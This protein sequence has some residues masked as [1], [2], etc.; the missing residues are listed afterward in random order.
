MELIDTHCHLTF[1]GL[2]EDVEGV[3]ERSRQAGVVQWITVGTD[4]EENLKVVELAGRFEG[5]YAAV[6]V[7]PHYASNVD[8]N[9]M[10]N[11]KDAANSEK[12]VAVGETGLDFHYN[13]SDKDSQKSVFQ[14]HLELAAETGLPVIV[15]C[16]DA[17]DDTMKLLEES[18]A[19][20]D[21][22][23]FHCFSGSAD[24]AGV[25]L[26]K[27]YYISF[28][29]VVTFKNAGHSREAAKAV[30]LN[31]L[32]VETDAPYMSPEPMRKQ[33]INEPALLVHTARFLAEIKGI[34]D[35]SFAGAVTSTSREFFRIQQ[36]SGC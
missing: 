30:P 26:A 12:V 21:K 4:M 36:L 22:I 23:V 20:V 18:E 15:H 3:L 5:L 6:G 31:R 32:M 11:L 33:K 19:V 29:G 28:T 24:E 9:V 1:G 27:G 16:R 8:R 14:R 17:F 34:K 35:E 7:H 2:A 13:L 10:R 25:V